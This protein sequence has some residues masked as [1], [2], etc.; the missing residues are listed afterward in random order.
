MSKTSSSHAVKEFT[1]A[2]PTEE[3]LTETVQ[4]ITAGVGEFNVLNPAARAAL[5]LKV[6]EQWEQDFIVKFH[7]PSDRVKA[8]EEYAAIEQGDK[9]PSLSEPVREA[10]LQRFDER[11]GDGGPRLWSSLNGK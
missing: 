3:G 5:V 1:K 6:T 11:Y 8:G 2:P 4:R 10:V 7:I 9:Y